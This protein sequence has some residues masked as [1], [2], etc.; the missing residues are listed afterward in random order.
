MSSVFSLPKQL[1]VIIA[2]L[3]KIL[4]TNI[5]AL[6]CAVAVVVVTE[7]ASRA[8]RPELVLQ[9]LPAEVT[10]A[11][12]TAVSPDSSIA[13]VAGFDQI[14]MFELKNGRRIRSLPLEGS[15]TEGRL[16]FSPDTTRLVA[17]CDEE[18]DTNSVYVWDTRTGALLDAVHGRHYAAVAF[19]KRER[20]I[21]YATEEYGDLDEP[22]GEIRTFDVHT[23][24]EIASR[25]RPTGC[26]DWDVSS[27][28]TRLACW[29]YYDSKPSNAVR[30]FDL[31]N[32]V[33]LIRTYALP[34][35]DFPARVYMS[36][37]AKRVAWVLE[38][39]GNS[40]MFFC[41]LTR[42]QTTATDSDGLSIGIDPLGDGVAF[43]VGNRIAYRTWDGRI[44]VTAAVKDVRVIALNAA[45]RSISIEEG[46]LVVRE[47]K[48]NRELS[49][50]H[51]SVTTYYDAI[52][53]SGL[54]AIFTPPDHDGRP[55]LIVFENGD[56]RVKP[57]DTFDEIWRWS[58]TDVR[59]GADRK[60]L[61]ARDGHGQV[62]T[63][64]IET[65]AHV[66]SSDTFPSGQVPA[67]RYHIETKAD[68]RSTVIR[69]TRGEELA[70]IYLLNKVDWAVI[71]PSGEFDT[72]LPLDQVSVLHWVLPGE[73]FRTFALDLFMREYYQPG[74]LA[75]ILN[76]N[77]TH[78]AACD[79]DLKHLPSVADINLAPPNVATPVPT[80]PQIDRR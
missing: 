35:K 29:G 44:V 16:V 42:C 79:T 7:S 41:D 15:C 43:A 48:T 67:P 37:N 69:S 24:I 12:W 30:L 58:P 8:Q 19:D 47:L 31:S 68:S 59:V 11:G 50:F 64:D 9:M 36:R 14:V 54:A 51:D 21:A 57:L 20:A 75:R 38:Q 3:M 73:P 55:H 23:D 5:Q 45:S 72:N 49:R 1:A 17:R 60:V 77:E 53:V 27:D 63:W 52:M 80:V 6:L 56:L 2:A 18:T 46:D 33:K 61:F 4:P 28:G 40:R 39:N 22:D 78:S 65:G 10:H 76:C 25:R 62:H 34:G 74:L 66:G 32:G 70:R 26:F 13:A 71:T